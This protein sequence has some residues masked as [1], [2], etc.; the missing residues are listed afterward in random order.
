MSVSTLAGALRDAELEEAPPDLGGA[1]RLW[2]AYRAQPGPMLALVGLA[3]LVA[4]A[5]VGPWI[6]PYDPAAVSFTA[7][8]Q[9]PS[10]AH[11]LGTD[12]T[13]RDILSRMI[14][15]ARVSL[16]TVFV[17]VL[18]ATALGVSI[19][20]AAGYVGGWLDLVLLRLTD[21]L[22]A[23][24]GL[25]IAMAVVAVLRPGLTSA[26]IGLTL[27]MAPGFVRLARAQV[28]AVSAETYVDASRAVGASSWR[29]VLRHIVPN[30]AAPI[31]VQVFLA[32]GYALLMEGAL[33]YLG[34]SVQPPLASW[35]SI[36]QDAF[37]AVELQPWF[38]FIPGAVITASVLCFN[39]VGEGLRRGLLH[40]DPAGTWF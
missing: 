21:A 32:L 1:R 25:L 28:Q 23:I 38:I 7:I 35:G 26:C 14:A 27:M 5:I 18:A 12:A 36:L 6:A 29:I 19:G 39:V 16:S 17:S 3:I 40:R 2:L 33:S 31:L 11:W 24:P 15:G 30:G 8:R 34:L 10:A 20:T 13:G 9:A 22:L 37:A 4:V